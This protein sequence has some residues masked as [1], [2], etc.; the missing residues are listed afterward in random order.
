MTTLFAISADMQSLDDLL[1]EKED[2]NDPEIQK[3]I[4]AWAEENQGNFDLKVDN[5]AALIKTME[6]R[7]SVRRDESK[8]LANRARIDEDAARSLKD[9]LK[10]VFQD[11]KIKKLETARFCVSIAKNGGLCPLEVD[12]S[13]IKDLP[14]NCKRII[15]EPDKETIRKEIESGKEIVGCKLLERGESLRI[16]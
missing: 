4:C 10:L 3:I 7:A 2:F 11:R 15:V 1:S 5:Y 13:K 12:E 6:A 9:R 8:R 14:E 16:R